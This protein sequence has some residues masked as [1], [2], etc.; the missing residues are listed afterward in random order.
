MNRPAC[1]DR[2]KTG[3]SG[4]EVTI[5]EKQSHLGGR[6]STMVQDGFKFDVGPT[7]FSISRC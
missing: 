5:V 3:E 2:K 7:F 1:S 6:T 4:V